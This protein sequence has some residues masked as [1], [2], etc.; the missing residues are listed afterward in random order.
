M[1]QE[2][3]ALHLQEE[4]RVMAAAEEAA[5]AAEA[6][7]QEAAAAAAAG[8][9]SY[10]PYSDGVQLHI[11]QVTAYVEDLDEYLESLYDDDMKVKVEATTYIA[12]LVGLD[13]YREQKEYP[14][15]DGPRGVA[16]QVAFER[17]TLKP[18]FSL[19]RLQV[20]GLKGYRLRAT[21]RLDSTCGAPPWRPLIT[22]L[23]CS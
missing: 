18:F 19:D 2:I 16:L 23:F 11:P 6:A 20:M 14:H 22:T 21:G 4:E 8:N 3:E 12:A 17:R 10:E 1:D 13:A 9:E 15:R 5:Y 7:A